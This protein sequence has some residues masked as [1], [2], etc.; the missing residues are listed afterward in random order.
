MFRTHDTIIAGGQFLPDCWKFAKLQWP[1]FSVVDGYGGFK[2]VHVITG[3]C[4]GVLLLYY[5]LNLGDEEGFPLYQLFPLLLKSHSFSIDFNVLER[6][7]MTVNNLDLTE[8]MP[9]L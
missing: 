6:S 9:P 7:P 3:F 2:D 1:L 5:H 8:N 4:L